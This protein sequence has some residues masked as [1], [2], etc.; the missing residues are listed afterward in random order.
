MSQPCQIDVSHIYSNLNNPATTPGFLN[1]HY[2]EPDGPECAWSIKIYYNQSAYSFSAFYVSQSLE[3]T[4]VFGERGSARL[5]LA[6]YDEERSLLPFVPVEEQYI[7]IWNT[8]ENRLYFAGYIRD[9]DTQLLAVR[10][11]S[12]EAC[13]VM[14]NCTD[15]YHELERKPVRKIY[16]DKK[17]GFILRD[18]LYRYTSLDP[19]DID[20][21]LGFQV[22]S[23]PINAKYPSQVLTHIAELTNTTYY[24][25][26]AS[27]KIQ[28]LP[29]ED[30]TAAF[31]ID[32]TDD[33]LYELFD[34]DSFSLRR[35]NDALKNQI[36]FW[37]S[38][39]YDK[40]TVNV[41][42]G[43]AIVVAYGDPPETDWADLP[44][45][46]EFKLKNSDAMYSVQKNNSNTEDQELRLSSP[47][48]EATATNQAYELRGNRR[49]LFVSDEESIGLMRTL[50]GDDG[51]FTYVVS[52][53]QNALTW[54]EARRFASALLALSRPLPQG[55]ATTYNTVFQHFPL[56][57][58][59]VLKF[60]LPN[61]KRFVGN[62]VVQQVTL[63]DLGGE[64]DPAE[65]INGEIHPFLQID[66]TFTATLNQTQTQ[67]RKMMQDLR[68]V[69]V[70][71]DET[72]VEDYRRIVETF[73]LKDCVHA[74]KPTSVSELLSLPDDVQVR[75]ET[76]QALFYTEL[77]YTLNLLDASFSSD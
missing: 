41:E 4:S 19:S 48:D 70:S 17:L 74:D 16:T 65:F 10:E 75:I 24:I 12:S 68:K 49:R 61:S 50:R 77:D 52:E 11:D 34:R 31:P 47:F 20:P 23:Y 25:E 27:R 73:A 33:T 28:L 59:R 7:E 45:G 64:V 57:A 55:Q 72:A 18:V 63:R 60:N 30:G 1:P 40:G 62:V 6:D 37:F 8:G 71:L 22:E 67:M 3:I 66:F 43:S 35:Q 9:V 69:K 14:L 54:N 46:L 15:L 26:P 36:E 29:K 13:L 51:I 21:N 42:N 76:D 38:E 53:D 58:G 32:V 39:R 2:V 56:L 44:A 5:T